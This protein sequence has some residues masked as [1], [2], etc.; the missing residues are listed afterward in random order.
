MNQDN[1][2]AHDPTINLTPAAAQDVLE[3]LGD[4]DFAD[5]GDG[6]EAAHAAIERVANGEDGATVTAEQ[7]A[8]AADFIREQTG[9]EDEHED[10][11][12]SLDAVAKQ[13]GGGSGTVTD[14]D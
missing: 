5:E 13:H 7:A 6:H 1:H 2:E 11:L 3:V 8:L 9:A 10:V 14:A 12:A 4:Y